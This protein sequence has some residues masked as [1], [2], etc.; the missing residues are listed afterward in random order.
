[1]WKFELTD[2][3]YFTPKGLTLSYDPYQLGPYAMGFVILNLDKAKLKGVI[4]DE[5]LNQTFENFN[6]ENWSKED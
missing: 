4:K 6:D 3:F 2:N 1:M 5:Y